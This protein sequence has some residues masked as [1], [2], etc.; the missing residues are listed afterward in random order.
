MASSVHYLCPHTTPLAAV[1]PHFRQPA[2][3]ILGIHYHPLSSLLFCEECDAV[4]CEQCVSCE[5]N[6]YYCPNCL[7]EVPAANIRSQ[8]NRCARNCFLC[9]QCQHTLSAVATDPP[10]SSYGDDPKA[11]QASLGEPPFFLACS[12]CRWDSKQVGISFEK[13]TLIAQQLHQAD[14][15]PSELLEFDRLKE[16]FEGYLKSQSLPSSS[17]APIHGHRSAGN[18]NSG[19]PAHLAASL[20]LSKEVP[21]VSR[22]GTQLGLSTSVFKLRSN[23]SLLSNSSVVLPANLNPDGT[24]KEDIPIYESLFSPGM[25]KK[26]SLK[27][28]ADRLAFYSHGDHTEPQDDGTNG[29]NLL[30]EQLTPIE[31][32]WD[33]AWDHLDRVRDLKPSRVPLRSKRT[34]RCPTCQHILI[35]PEQ[36]AQSIRFKIKLIAS[37]YLPLIE[38]YRKRIATSTKLGTDRLT[39]GISA[40]RKSAAA[41]R[42]GTTAASNPLLGRVG[43]VPDE[44]IR[45]DRK[46]QFEMTFVNPLYEP[47]NV[48]LTISPP[49][50]VPSNV[51][52]EPDQIPYSV[53]L[54]ASEF[55]IAAFAEVWEY[56]DEDE[57]EGGANEDNNEQKETDEA[58]ALKRNRLSTFGLADSARRRTL[59]TNVVTKKANRTTILVEAKTNKQFVGTLQADML[60][61]FTYQSDDLNDEL[62]ESPTRPG[63]AS[64][65]T[66]GGGHQSE[67]FHGA[68]EGDEGPENQK[69]FTFWTK[70]TF[71][72]VVPL[73]TLQ[74]PAQ[75]ATVPSSAS[76]RPPQPSNQPA[77]TTGSTSEPKK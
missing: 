59:P 34:K 48:R 23:H 45:P 12:F 2:A 31:K 75:P 32:K 35:K 5:L 1:P 15:S 69:S 51:P 55:T 37:N 43:E 27:N 58:V 24:W 11:P 70:L 53:H 36:K 60:V 29:G 56:D 20:A 62:E 77:P 72:E 68:A 28:D 64:S 67:E 14:S 41:S 30:I 19:S 25:A 33:E 44:V 7:F 47:I 16:H 52:G 38:L 10:S 65:Y 8:K 21:T 57:A 39:S 13:P 73:S 22:Y 9:P 71:G 74:P 63:P 54:L 17:S 76:V 49:A 6:C 50:P 4:R 40:A 18:L 42:T 3:A 46:Y 66:K 61:T 26:S